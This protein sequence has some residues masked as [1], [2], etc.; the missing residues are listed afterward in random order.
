MFGWYLMWVRCKHKISRDSLRKPRDSQNAFGN[1]CNNVANAKKFFVRLATVLQ[2]PESFSWDLQRC[3]KHQKVF[4][5]T[6]NGVANAKKFF[7]RLATVLQTP[8]SFSWDSQRCCKRWKVLRGTCCIPAKTFSRDKTP[9]A[10]VELTLL[11]WWDG[12]VDSIDDE[13]GL[14]RCVP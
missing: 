11:N 9:H 6:C 4:R 5:E 7:V 2:T 14:I 13:G 12:L 10:F 3:C 1:A 8:K